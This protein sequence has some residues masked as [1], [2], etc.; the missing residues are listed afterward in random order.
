MSDL[1]SIFEQLE[2]T[3][4]RNDKIEI[5]SKHIDNQDL[6]DA[7]FYAYNPYINFFIKQIPKIDPTAH[8]GELK[9]ADGLRLMESVTNKEI[10]GS[11]ARKE[12]IADVLTRLNERDADILRRV[13]AKNLKCGSTRSTFNKVKN[14]IPKFNVLLAKEFNEDTAAG[15]NA[16]YYVQ[17]KSDG[18]RASA[19]VTK[20]KIGFFSREGNELLVN[21]PSIKESLMGLHEKLGYDYMIDGELVLFDDNGMCNRQKSN[22]IINKAIVGSINTKEDSQLRYYV[23]D[24][25]PMDK[26]NQ[27]KDTTPYSERLKRLD[28][29]NDLR[30]PH[31]PLEVSETYIVNTLEEI[32]P[33]IDS[34]I[35]KGEE[36]AVVKSHDLVWEDR[37]S[38][39]MLKAKECH[40]CD[41][42]AVSWNPRDENV[43]N[44]KGIGSI[45]FES[46]DGVVK[47]A[48]SSGLSYEMC[49]YV[50]DQDTGEYVFDE[51]FDCDKYNQQ[52]GKILYNKKIPNKDGTGFTL[53]SPRIEV[54]RAD[55]HEA[56]DNESIK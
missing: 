52:I 39:H 15:L 10:T 35:Q 42:I 13:I 1:K 29:F 48:V 44:N 2:A 23:W 49:G 18:S 3:R 25:V 12:Y 37:R 30:V 34:F 24:V 11:N 47:V 43:R 26:F 6:V 7:F 38:Q 32:T 8:T 19:L 16:P 20:E 53:F 28:H 33:I 40:D 9:F 5:I 50:K 22:G 54:F 21:V 46:R 45:N 51:T 55:K 41:L 36:G 17:L 27:G 31:A 4:S 14:I 56:D